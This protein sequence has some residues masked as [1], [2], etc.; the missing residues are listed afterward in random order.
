M[1]DYVSLAGEGLA[2]QVDLRD[3]FGNPAV[4]NE[5][6]TLLFNWAMLST[7]NTANGLSSGT[8]AE[9]VYPGCGPSSILFNVTYAGLYNVSLIVNNFHIPFSQNESM[10]WDGSSTG[11]S[12]TAVNSVLIE[13]LSG[14]INF[15]KSYV[16]VNFGDTVTV[17]DSL[18]FNFLIYD[19]YN[20]W[21][22]SQMEL[23]VYLTGAYEPSSDTFADNETNTVFVEQSGTDGGLLE[24]SIETSGSY[25][26]Q[27]DVMD[28]LDFHFSELS[29]RGQAAV[30]VGCLV[31]KLIVEPGKFL[32]LL[33]M[34][35]VSLSGSLTIGYR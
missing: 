15:N 35:L 24:L 13:V 9:V 26:L 7:R 23:I 28:T 11:T 19:D 18:T 27:S 4:V 21:L 20:N 14:S 6:T 30:S 33:Q 34:T 3:V 31:R 16:E 1:S 29:F 25:I 2:L 8:W 5:S 32:Y 22:L 12:V 17:N 10:S